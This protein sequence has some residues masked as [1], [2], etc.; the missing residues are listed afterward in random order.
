MSKKIKKSGIQEFKNSKK[1]QKKKKKTK[2]KNI[3]QKSKKK[4][5]RS[6]NCKKKQMAKNV[7][8]VLVFFPKKSK[9]QNFTVSSSTGFQFYL[10]R[11]FSFLEHLS[12]F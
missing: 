1:I 7:K 2:I 10:F 5:K 8:T 6:E 12:Y 9:I 11:V 3:Y 4:L